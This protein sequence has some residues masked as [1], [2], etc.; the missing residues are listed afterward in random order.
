MLSSKYPQQDKKNLFLRSFEVVLCE[1][2][3]KPAETAKAESRYGSRLTRSRISI[4]SSA[5]SRAK[6]EIKTLPSLSSK[7]T[8]KV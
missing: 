5:S 7:I 1:A 6:F 2:L 8:V 3:T 4:H